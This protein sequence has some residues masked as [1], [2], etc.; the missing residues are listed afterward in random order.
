MDRKASAL[1]LDILKRQQQSGRLQLYLPEDVEVAHKCGDLDFLE[2]TA[3]SSFFR[4]IP[5]FWPY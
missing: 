4:D 2:M 5:I 1:M 3:E